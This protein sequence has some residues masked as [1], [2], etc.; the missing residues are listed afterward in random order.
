MYKLIAP[1]HA[2]KM[3]HS[4]NYS[5]SVPR[6]TNSPFHKQAKQGSNPFP[7]IAIE[8]LICNFRFYK[9]VLNKH[10]VGYLACSALNLF[11]CIE[12]RIPRIYAH[13]SIYKKKQD[14][15]I[16]CIYV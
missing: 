9:N 10:F 4:K 5:P 16:M 2:S 3:I 8:T 13:G 15:T 12:I 7:R 1:V 11:H 6:I 14:K